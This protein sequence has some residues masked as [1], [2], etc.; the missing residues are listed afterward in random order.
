VPSDGDVCIIA[1]SDSQ[2]G[3]LMTGACQ[4]PA[5]A[6]TP[7]QQASNIRSS[8]PPFPHHPLKTAMLVQ[9]CRVVVRQPQSLCLSQG[10]IPRSPPSSSVLRGIPL[11]HTACPQLYVACA[12]A[13]YMMPGHVNNLSPLCPHLCCLQCH[14]C[15]ACPPPKIDGLPH[16]CK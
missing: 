3:S 15:N 8:R 12:A 5:L 6:A 14:S 9:Q 7:V 16:S 13:P 4:P 10:C 1:L 11:A 2:R